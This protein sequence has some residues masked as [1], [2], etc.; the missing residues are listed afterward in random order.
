MSTLICNWFL[1][2]HETELYSWWLIDRDSLFTHILMEQKRQ[3]CCPFTKINRPALFFVAYRI[4]N[5]TKNESSNSSTKMLAITSF[6]YNPLLWT[7]DILYSHPPT[8]L[9]VCPS[10]HATCRTTTASCWKR[11]RSETSIMITSRHD[12]FTKS[13]WF[14][15]RI[16]VTFLDICTRWAWL[17]HDERLVRRLTAAELGTCTKSHP[18]EEVMYMVISISI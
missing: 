4:S 14:R 15:A 3:L 13:Q 5:C 1:G 9:F 7:L 17:S 8:P 10:H 11:P 12:R 2:S 16:C 18:L 6:Y